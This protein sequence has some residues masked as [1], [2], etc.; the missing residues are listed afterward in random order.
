MTHELKVENQKM[1]MKIANYLN[2]ALDIATFLNR[3]MMVKRVVV[4]LFNHLV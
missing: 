3:P 2:I 4:E 1:E